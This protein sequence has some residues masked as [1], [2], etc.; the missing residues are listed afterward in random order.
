MLYST[1]LSF[2]FSLFILVQLYIFLEFFLNSSFPFTFLSIFFP[3]LSIYFKFSCFLYIYRSSR[4]ILL[5]FQPSFNFLPPCTFLAIAR[6]SSY[7]VFSIS[8][9]S[10]I[11]P[12][13]SLS[14]SITLLSLSLYF[15]SDD[16][17]PPGRVIRSIHIRRRRKPSSIRGLILL[18]ASACLAITRTR[19]IDFHT[20]LSNCIV[21]RAVIAARIA[22][23]TRPPRWFPLVHDDT[24]PSN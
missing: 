5:Y 20:P 1:F 4:L 15:L 10:A 19:R 13:L 6:V 12:I 11:F 3:I 9:S 24:R 18:A 8:F 14:F 16:P 2:R 7:S 17:P 21:G 22:F 23:W